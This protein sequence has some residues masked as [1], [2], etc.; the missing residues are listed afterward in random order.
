VEFANRGDGNAANPSLT[1]NRFTSFVHLRCDFFHGTRIAKASGRSLGSKCSFSVS[2][3]GM[4]NASSVLV[5]GTRFEVS[6]YSYL[7]ACQMRRV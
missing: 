4:A 3:T 7:G 1:Q 2:S 5:T 6:P